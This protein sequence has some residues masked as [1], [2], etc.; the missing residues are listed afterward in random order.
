MQTDYIDVYMLHWP[1]TALCAIS[2]FTKA[3]VVVPKVTDSFETLEKLKRQGKIRHIGVSNFG[4]ERLSQLA[5]GD[6]KSCST[7]CH[8]R[9]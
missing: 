4:R 2:H 7:N 1:V 9:C 3:K 5:T 8:T 6:A